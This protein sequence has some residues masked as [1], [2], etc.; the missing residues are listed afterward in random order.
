V[1]LTLQEAGM[2]MVKFCVSL[3]LMSFTVPGCQTADRSGPPAAAR[4]ENLMRMPLADAFAP[5]REVVVSFVE[6][7]PNSTLARHGHPGEE[8]Y[9]CLEGDAR[10][11]IDGEPDIIATP[12][13]VGHIPFKKM[14]SATSG[15]QGVKVVVFRVHTRGESDRYLEEGGVA[16]R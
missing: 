5:G 13:A 12:G 4:V 10:V 3:V 6:L 14:H 8:F 16:G 7:P 15:K 2:G 1:F 9:Y 11:L